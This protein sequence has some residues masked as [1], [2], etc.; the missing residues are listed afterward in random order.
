[1]FWMLST[2]LG[3]QNVRN[4]SCHLHF[5]LLVLSSSVWRHLLCSLIFCYFCLHNTVCSLYLFAAAATCHMIMCTIWWLLFRSSV[6]TFSC[7]LWQLILFYFHF[8]YLIFLCSSPD[9]MLVSQATI[10]SKHYSFFCSSNVSV[11]TFPLLPTP[12]LYPHPPPP[13]P[14]PVLWAALWKCLTPVCNAPTRYPHSLF[15]YTLQLLQTPMCTLD[16]GRWT[17]LET[18]NPPNHPHSL[19]SF[20]LLSC[21]LLTCLFWWYAM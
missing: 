20:T 5:R 12:P 19:S 4:K 7:F 9:C 10:Q 18:D 11:P 16:H 15:L 13:P 3:F 8:F 1:M 6:C 2:H 21:L 14:P 17:C